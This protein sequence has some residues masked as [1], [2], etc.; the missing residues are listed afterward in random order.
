MNKEES[1][2]FAGLMESYLKIPSF[3]CETIEKDLSDGKYKEVIEYIIQRRKE[4][5][6]HSFDT[7][8]EL[9]KSSLIVN[10]NTKNEQ[11]IKHGKKINEVIDYIN[12]KEG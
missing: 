12:K 3:L 9:P 7:V 2:Y 1:I 4:L 8:E 6:E 10:E 5:E 11:L